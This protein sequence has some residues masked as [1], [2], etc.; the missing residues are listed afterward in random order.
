MLWALAFRFSIIVLYPR[1]WDLAAL[2]RVYP[3]HLF[4]PLAVQDPLLNGLFGSGYTQGIQFN[5][6]DPD[7]LQAVVTLKHW[8]VFVQH[9]RLPFPLNLAHLC[10]VLLP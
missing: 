8:G 6:V 5:S 1:V 9:V 2:S 3:T 10:L 7:H 4:H